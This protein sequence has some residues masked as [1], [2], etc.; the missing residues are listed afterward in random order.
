MVETDAKTIFVLT[1]DD[2]LECARQLGIPDKAITADVLR[3]GK[4]GVK[5]GFENWADVV[6]SAIDFALKS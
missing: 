1:R 6:K 2:V 5:F 3:Q 4:K